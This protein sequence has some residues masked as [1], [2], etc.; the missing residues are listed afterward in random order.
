MFLNINFQYYKNLV[1]LHKTFTK[2]CLHFTTPLF[3]TMLIMYK[4]S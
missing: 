1:Q 3:Y 4:D 2:N